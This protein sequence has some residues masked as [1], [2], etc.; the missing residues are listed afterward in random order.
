[1]TTMDEYKQLRQLLSQE[2]ESLKKIVYQLLR[3]LRDFSNGVNVLLEEEHAQVEE[4]HYQWSTLQNETTHYQTTLK[5]HATQFIEQKQQLKTLETALQTTVEAQHQRLTTLEKYH[6]ADVVKR[7]AEFEQRWQTLQKNIAAHEIHLQEQSAELEEKTRSLATIETYIQVQLEQQISRLNALEKH[8]PAELVK[9]IADGEQQRQQLHQELLANQARL[10]TQAEALALATKK[11]S[12]GESSINQRLA[13]IESLQAQLAEYA[14]RL[15]HVEQ[16]NPAPQVAQLAHVMAEHAQQLALLAQ[17]KARLLG[18]SEAFQTQLAEQTTRLQILERDHPAEL[19]QRLAD[20][21]VRWEEIKA[22]EGRLTDTESRISDLAHILPHAIRQASAQQMQNGIASEAE[23]TESLKEPVKNCLKQSVSED[24]QSLADALFPVMG[25]AIRKSINESL[26]GLVQDLNVRL[27]HSVLSPRGISWRIEAMRSGRSFAEVVLHNTLVY[28]VEEVF[29]IHRQTGILLQHLHQEDSTLGDSDAISGMLT[30]IQDFTRDSFSKDKTEELDRIE[31]GDYTVWLERAPHAVLACVIRGV[32]PYE[33]RNLMRSVLEKLH[34]R[35]GRQLEYFEG[36]NSVFESSQPLLQNAL[37]SQ[38]KDEVTRREKRFFSLPLLFVLCLLLIG[39][40]YGSYR[41]WQWQQTL[42]NYIVQLKNT[43]GLV[44]IETAPLDGKLQI[45]LLRDPL[46]ADPNE[47]AQRMQVADRI[48]LHSSPHYDLTS[49]FIVQRARQRLKPPATVQLQ[50]QDV[51][52]LQISGYAQPE[53]IKTAKQEALHVVGVTDIETTN[54]EETDV[55]LLRQAQEKVQPPSTL[56]QLSVS[57]AV[58]TLA[59][60]VDENEYARIQTQIAHLTGYAQ[61]DT[62]GLRN[63]TEVLKTLSQQIETITVYF[64][65]DY[66]FSEGQDPAL[67]Q[68]YSLVQQM[69]T[70]A[71]RHQKPLVFQISGYTDG[72][73]T[74]LHNY[75]LSQ[76]RAERVYHD[77]R[78]RGIDIKYLLVVPPPTVPFGD[79]TPNY[80]ERRVLI[81]V[82][83]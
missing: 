21:E 3:D 25:P 31:L 44:V 2:E 66:N 65:E 6:P 48:V 8:H 47:I 12:V 56:T 41:Y 60:D 22:I 9:R 42:S 81:K 67:T 5:A 57:N 32:P 38:K 24:T 72:L 34:A 36:D 35:Y 15:S 79:V 70:L 4:L 64:G 7:L 20:I 59:G 53:W 76:Q 1:M 11:I 27:E 49:D 17:D 33:F 80:L 83:M 82:K 26:K 69:I 10:T 54:L 18:Q 74:Q 61:I 73:G 40:F 77:L 50:L 75:T 29:L 62:T 43:A 58:L 68:L 63:I 55:F 45:R 37:Q 23:L 28:R 30:A 46:A 78:N 51:S 52:H 16:E 14:R 39:I 19:V 71:D 13:E